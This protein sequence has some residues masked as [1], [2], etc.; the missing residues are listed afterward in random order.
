MRDQV[1]PGL[2]RVFWKSGGSSLASVGITA[3]GGKWLAPTNWVSPTTDQS[4]WEDIDRLQAIDYRIKIKAGDFVFCVG[5]GIAI[6]PVVSVNAEHGTAYLNPAVHDI[7]TGGN[8]SLDKLEL[9]R[10]SEHAERFP[11]FC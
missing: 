3:D 9:V 7:G 8:E 6:F 4:A 1:K 5:D 11:Q 10:D 2:Y